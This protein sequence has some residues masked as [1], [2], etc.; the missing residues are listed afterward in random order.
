MIDT[1]QSPLF[2]KKY[3]FLKILRKK[4]AYLWSISVKKNKKIESLKN[5]ITD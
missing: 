2:E 4:L 5:H 1:T 3:T